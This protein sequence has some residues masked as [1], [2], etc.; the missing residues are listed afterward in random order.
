MKDNFS[1]RAAEYARFRPGYP[2][3]LFYFLFAR[4]K[5]FDCA[6]DCATGN[7]QI[8]AV[9]AEH[10]RQVDATD[11]SENQLKNAV[12]WP[13]IRYQTAAAEAP[14]FPD[15]T[16]D[17]VTVGQAAHWFDLEKFY[18]EV[19]RVL[20]PGGVLALVGYG[21]L[22]IDAATDRVIDHLYREVLGGYWDPERRHIDAAL[23]RIPFPF[24]EIPLP[25]MV[26]EYAWTTEHLLGYLSTWSAV[27]HFEI[28]TGVS[29][30]GDSFVRDLEK[31]WG[32]APV[33]TVRFPIFGRIGRS[34]SSV[35]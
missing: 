32:D 20:K 10:F 9:L 27:Q 2:A 30:L 35:L 23:T 29:P 31:A 15:Q 18:P 17:L 33:K 8:A 4:C 3:A 34:D 21:L 7:G 13:N 19:R 24:R 6:W 5:H 1:Y 25:E 28:Q 11:I 22:K 14:L 26:M 16:F 12:Q